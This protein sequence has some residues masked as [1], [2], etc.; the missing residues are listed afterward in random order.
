[1]TPDW[2]T[3]HHEGDEQEN[4][5]QTTAQLSAAITSLIYEPRLRRVPCPLLDLVKEDLRDLERDSPSSVTT[6]FSV[7]CFEGYLGFPKFR[8]V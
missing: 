3:V 4:R 5:P 7:G 2:L 6:R 1:M 8:N